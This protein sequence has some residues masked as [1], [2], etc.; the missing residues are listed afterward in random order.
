MPAILSDFRKIVVFPLFPHHTLSYRECYCSLHFSFEGPVTSSP[1]ARPA[2]PRVNINIFSPVDCSR[3][4]VCCRCLR[5]WAWQTTSPRT[6]EK[7]RHNAPSKVYILRYSAP[8]PSNENVEKHKLK[9]VK[10]VCFG[11]LYVAL[12]MQVK[13]AASRTRKQLERWENGG[14]STSAWSRLASVH[15]HRFPF[16]CWNAPVGVLLF[17]NHM[18][19]RV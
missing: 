18:H 4:C 1:R 14:K 7:R 11:S 8:R 10:V 9:V 16:A 15:I 17:K 13:T 3:Y 12:F 6:L 19:A 2:R 5:S